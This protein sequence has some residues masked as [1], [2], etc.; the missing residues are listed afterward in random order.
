VI[1]SFRAPFTFGESAVSSTPGLKKKGTT[2][3]TGV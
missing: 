2:P 1:A 3:P